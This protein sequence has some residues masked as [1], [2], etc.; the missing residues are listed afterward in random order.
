MPAHPILLT[1]VPAVLLQI[2]VLD[3]LLLWGVHP[4]LLP[5]LVFLTGIRQ[6]PDRGA[7]AG[8]LTGG[9]LFLTGGPPWMIVLY[10]LTGGVSGALFHPERRFFAGWLRF[11]PVAAAA[12]GLL[13]LLHWPARAAMAAAFSLACPELLLSLLCFP[14]AA[15]LV[16]WTGP[17]RTAPR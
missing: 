4:S 6:G 14:P 9:L 11:L 17:G 16:H 2:L 3:R 1:A 7:A 5:A 13:V 8:L 10:S 15:L 12:E